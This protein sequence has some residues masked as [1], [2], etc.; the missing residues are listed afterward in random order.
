ME[1]RAVGMR[2]LL[3]CK[4][5]DWLEGGAAAEVG[6][7]APAA[8]FSLEGAEDCPSPTTSM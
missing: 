8:P 6:R 1:G 4:G 3:R 2:R 7:P 5:R